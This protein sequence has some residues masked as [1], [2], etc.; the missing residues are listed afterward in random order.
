[1]LLQ[2]MAL[3]L[4]LYRAVKLH[5]QLGVLQGV[6]D[7]VFTK[8]TA[9]IAKRR[10]SHNLDTAL[11]QIHRIESRRTQTLIQ[12][13]LHLFQPRKTKNCLTTSMA[14]GRNICKTPNKEAPEVQ[15]A[16]QVPRK[17]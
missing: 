14:F 7:H 15:L 11:I 6:P 3:S 13:P 2:I 17:L 9:R 12:V 8:I 4:L 1:M 10:K 5:S 16:E